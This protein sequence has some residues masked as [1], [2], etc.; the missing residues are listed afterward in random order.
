MSSYAKAS[1]AGSIGGAGKLIGSVALV[2]AALVVFAAPA[3]AGKVDT[4]YFAGDGEGSGGNGS[5]DGQLLN[6]GQ[7]DV[8]AASGE[9]YVADTGNNRV[10]IFQPTADLAEY[11]S[12]AAISE[13]TGLAI[14]QA[15]G[16]VYVANAAGISKFDESLVPVAAEWADPGVTGSLA[17]D[18]GTGDLLVADTEG[19]LVRRFESDGT[20]AGTFAAER[21][22]D[23]AVDSTG[24]I[25]VVTS[26]GNVIG[27]CGPTSSVVRFSST[28][29]EAG[30]VG[31]SLVAP[32]AVAVDPDDDSI[33]VATHVG[34][35][36]CEAG[37]TPEVVS[38]D[39]SGA[40]L[41]AV[42]LTGRVFMP[43]ANGNAMF[44]VVPGL[45]AAGAGSDRVYVVTKS[46]AGDIYGATKVAVI[47]HSAPLTMPLSAHPLAG[48]TR[49]LIGG[50]VNPRDQQTDY[51]LEYGL[52]ASYGTS[53]PAGED[54]EAGSGQQYST[55]T[56]EIAG[57]TPETTYHFRIV[58]ENA[59]GK[60]EGPDGT[61]NTMP[62]PAGPESCPNEAIRAM[63]SS[64][65]SDCRAWEMVSP[66]EKNFG[67]VATTTLFPTPVLSSPD[68]NTVFYFANLAF[69]DAPAAQPAGPYLA[70]RG[71]SGWANRGISGPIPAT[72][73]LDSKAP[74]GRFNSDDL[75]K[76][77]VLASAEAG[78]TPDTPPIPRQAKQIYVRDNRTNTFE[79][80]SVGTPSNIPP[81]VGIGEAPMVIDATPDLEHVLFA[82]YYAYTSDATT[83]EPF[84]NGTVNLYQWDADEPETVKLVG[85]LPGG[86]VEPGGVAPGDRDKTPTKVL[87]DDG[88]RVFFSSPPD[89]GNL[90]VR[91]DGSSTV[92]I[93]ADGRY[94]TASSDGEEVLFLDGDGLE[95]YDVGSGVTT[96]LAAGP[97]RGEFGA[98]FGVVEASDDLSHVYFITGAQLGFDD[99]LLGE[100]NLFLSAHGALRFIATVTGEDA[101]NLVGVPN[102]TSD[103]HQARISPDDGRLAFRSG[104]QLTAYDNEGHAQVYLY[105]PN[106]EQIS[107]ISCPSSGKEPEGSASLISRGNN[108][109]IFAS[110][111]G[112]RNNFSADGTR[113]F[114]ETTDSLSPQDTNG[115]E[116]IYQLSGGL[117]RLVTPGV[118]DASDGY[119]FGGASAD[120]SS[121]FFGTRNPVVAQDVDKLSD[122]YVARVN[123]GI[124]AQ[125]V[126]GP[127]TAPCEGQQCRGPSAAPLAVAAPASNAVRGS[128]NATP[129]KHKKK[130]HKKKQ[131]KK[132]H[133]KNHKN[134][135]SRR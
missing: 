12:Q 62:L 89:S 6:P 66:V 53:V 73:P 97:T 69:G 23:L 41:E 40:L 78:L 98:Q 58:A 87:S 57:L 111:V 116:D 91:K 61:F 1:S 106:D 47:A 2:I 26:T 108:G 76:S 88:R 123:G 60:T 82:S 133:H 49:A 51:W 96:H 70:N 24:E 59:T 131:K 18:P 45:A 13:P 124:A 110:A 37:F 5:A 121:V 77:L 102:D 86:E 113:L 99:A 55:L 103:R 94:E 48:G 42:A 63:Q 79:L 52:T 50:R 4:G 54:G 72:G 80:V 85:Y 95:R 74:F 118:G 117:V 71:S 38:F 67:D 128:K 35:Y 68:G 10:Q 93:S 9:I 81:G 31:S 127:A 14:D 109:L 122:L 17:V 125:N 126:T 3:F 39:S 11:D 30:V 101:V 119:L 75:S 21:P 32:G 34:E 36:F 114:F 33:V 15:S 134:G 20:A 135:S 84:L 7:S 25:F 90:Y 22:I 65:A 104:V 115:T 44:A 64:T 83:A 107:C 120:G 16:D 8:N 105:D 92:Q 130:H 19:N 29:V 27:E 46:P 43:G 132:K 129:K 56:R 100:P 28:G 112:D